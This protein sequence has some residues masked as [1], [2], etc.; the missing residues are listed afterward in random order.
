MPNELAERG[1]LM[2]LSLLSHKII[3]ILLKYG[4]GGELTEKQKETLLR[5]KE[6]ILD[7]IIKASKLCTGEEI[8][9]ISGLWEG[10]RLYGY[11][12]VALA[13]IN[14]GSFDISL[15]EKISATI[16]AIDAGEKR[17]TLDS[18]WARRFF[19]SFDEQIRPRRILS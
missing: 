4:E 3:S 7:K 5:G 19:Q 12:L 17:E 18:T 11:A 10:I 14:S 8:S 1:I 2:Q 15:F 6:L 9:D 16:S 13:D